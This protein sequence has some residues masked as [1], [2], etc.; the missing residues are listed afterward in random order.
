[1]SPFHYS[2]TYRVL[3]PHNHI[4]FQ[5]WLGDPYDGGGLG[6]VEVDVEE[7]ADD[8]DDGGDFIL[9]MTWMDLETT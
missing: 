3:L 8:D 9:E 7:E 2:L 1:M 5:A 6:A 4:D